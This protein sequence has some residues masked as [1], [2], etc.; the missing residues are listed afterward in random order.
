[1]VGHFDA[2]K[3]VE[4]VSSKDPTRL[5]DT[6]SGG[7]ANAL[8]VGDVN[9]IHDYPWPRDP[10]PSS[11]QYAMIG[12]VWTHFFSLFHCAFIHDLAAPMM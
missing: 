11:S 6:N 5:V 9:D 1:M 2:A 10:K 7:P 3:V 12:E 4:W 8:K